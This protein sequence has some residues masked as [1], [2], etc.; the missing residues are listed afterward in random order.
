MVLVPFVT[1]SLLT[2]T[3][4]FNNQ[5]MRKKGSFQVCPKENDGVS[6]SFARVNL[7][8]KIEEKVDVVSESYF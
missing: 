1:L 7:T 8:R 6:L 4:V 2:T 5:P 3:D